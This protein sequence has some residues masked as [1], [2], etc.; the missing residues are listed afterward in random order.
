MGDSWSAC[1]ASASMLLIRLKIQVNTSNLNSMTTIFGHG[2]I[3]ASAS[4]AATTSPSLAK[5]LG[6]VMET[7]KIHTRDRKFKS[8][9]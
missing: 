6:S 4:T 5:T 9:R 7:F 1:Q 3:G 8:M 2:S